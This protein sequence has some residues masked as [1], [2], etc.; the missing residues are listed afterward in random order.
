VL[1]TILEVVTESPTSLTVMC[2]AGVSNNRG[3]HARL[4]CSG[5]L[6]VMVLPVIRLFFFRFVLRVTDLPLLDLLSI[7]PVLL[8]AFLL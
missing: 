5:F 3:P 7:R 6:V 2:P 4:A 1:E 8:L